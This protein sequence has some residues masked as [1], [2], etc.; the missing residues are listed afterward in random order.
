MNLQTT[1]VLTDEIVIKIYLDEE[2]VAPVQP[3]A[4]GAQRKPGKI[5]EPKF[6]HRDED[7]D[8]QDSDRVV[9]GYNPSDYNNLNV[10]QEVRDLFKYITR[11]QKMFEYNFEDTKHPIWILKQVSRLSF[12]I[13]FQLWEK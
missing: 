10:D 8:D 3:K 5:E 6:A 12:L 2:D 13:I 11:Y 9:G 1:E 7:D 4:G